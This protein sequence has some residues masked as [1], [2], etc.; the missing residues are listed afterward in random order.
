M[1]SRKISKKLVNYGSRTNSRTSESS[2][3]SDESRQFDSDESLSEDDEK[4]VSKGI[5]GEIF[6]NRYICIK[7][8]GKGTFCRV[9]LVYDI[10]NLEF[11]AMKIVFCKYTEEAEHEIE[12]YKHLGNK[13]NNVTKFVDSF[14]YNECVCMILELMGICLIDLFNYYSQTL[15]KNETESALLPRELTKKIFHDLFMGL[16][17]LHNKGIVHTDLKPENIMINIFPYKIEKI[18]KWFNSTDIIQQYKSLLLESLPDNFDKLDTNKKK[19]VKKKCRIKTLTKIKLYT[20]QTVLSYHKQIIDEKLKTAE[21]IIDID[22]VSDFSDF[23]DL[24]TVDENE[25]FDMIPLNNLVAK[26]I[27]LGNAESVDDFEPD[28]IQLRCYRPPENILNEY[29]NT[30]SDIWSMGCLLYETLTGEYLF[31]IDHDRFRDSFDRD[32]ELLVQMYNAIG[33]LPID[34]TDKSIYKDDL[35]KENS[36]K[37]KDIESSRFEKKT[38]RELLILNGDKIHEKEL[39]LLTNLFSRIFE[40]TLDKRINADDVIRHDW[41]K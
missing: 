37:I 30:K 33:E 11:Y 10:I 27:D 16:R 17:E 1:Y 4:E 13:Y 40:Y 8:L 32:K 39:D 41:F 23:S 34:Y 12:M 5:V 36:N 18:K 24:E 7:Y 26:I 29:F 9:W 21:E 38:I 35:F 15:S 22:D 31:E 14:R 25:L 28:F 6:F 19:I 2:S 20:K 3:N